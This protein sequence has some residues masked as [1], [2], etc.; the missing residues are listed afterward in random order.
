[1]CCIMSRMNREA[2]YTKQKILE[3]VD[4]SSYNTDGGWGFQKTAC[5]W[6]ILVLIGVQHF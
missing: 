4:K 5:Q 3:G 2:E 6:L 1:M